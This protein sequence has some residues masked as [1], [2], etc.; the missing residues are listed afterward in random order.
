ME[1]ESFIRGIP[2]CRSLLS[3]IV[4]DD[5]EYTLVYKFPTDDFYT[6]RRGQG[7]YKNGQRI[8]V[9][10][11]PLNRAWIEGKPESNTSIMEVTKHVRAVNNTH[12]F[13]YVVEGA[14]DGWISHSDKGGLWDYVPRTM[15]M[16]EAG[17]KVANIGSQTYDYKNFAIVAAHPDN[18]AEL[19]AL[20]SPKP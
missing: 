11:R 6:A 12:E 4:N 9:R 8:K 17:L 14:L 15:L 13:L 19:S 3:L 5:P 20:L 18:F 10:Y 16:E 1:T 7:A 2:S